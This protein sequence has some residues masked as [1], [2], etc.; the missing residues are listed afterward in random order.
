MKAL[1]TGMSGTGKSTVL[2]ALAA[3]GYRTADTD[4]D[5]LTVWDESAEE[6]LWDEPRIDALLSAPD[7]LFLSGTTRNQLR[8]YPRLDHVILLSAP[9]PVIVRR[10]ET[11]T[12]NPYGKTPEERDLVLHH[13]A[14]V[15]PLLRRGASLEVVTTIP[16]AEVVTRILTHCG[17]Q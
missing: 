13:L 17:L 4:Y 15:E 8:F 16:I 5:D 1:I 3:R 11:R 10:L 7:P 6:W 12:S 9:A 14:T 2:A